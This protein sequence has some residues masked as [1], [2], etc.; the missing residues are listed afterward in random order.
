MIKLLVNKQE[1]EIWVKNNVASLMHATET[2]P[3]LCYM[4]N[5]AYGTCMVINR[6]TGKVATSRCS[7]NDKFNDLIGIAVA[8]AKYKG[9]PIPVVGRTVVLSSLNNNDVFIYNYEKYRIIRTIGSICCFTGENKPYVLVE[10]LRDNEQ[11]CVPA[12]ALV[13]QEYR[14][15]YFENDNE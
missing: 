2:N 10:S 5:E 6:K 3:R 14:G 9:K 1:F 13:V 12:Y 15:G 4:V 8:W 11:Y 7:P